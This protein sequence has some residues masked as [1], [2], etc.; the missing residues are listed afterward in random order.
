MKVVPV[1]KKSYGKF[2][3]GDSY[4]CLSVGCFLYFACI[5]V[6]EISISWGGIYL[7]TMATVMIFI[8]ILVAGMC[9]E[10]RLC[11]YLRKIHYVVCYH[12]NSGILY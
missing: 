5:I 12:G 6:L 7:A 3:T 8:H 11:E 9:A 1:E 4:I 2:H 10:V